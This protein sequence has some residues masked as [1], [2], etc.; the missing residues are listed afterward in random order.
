MK[1]LRPSLFFFEFGRFVLLDKE[2]NMIR[3]AVDVWSLSLGHLDGYD[4]GI[5][6]S[7]IE[8]YFEKVIARGVHCVWGVEC[9]SERPSARCCDDALACTGCGRHGQLRAGA[10]RIERGRRRA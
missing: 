6:V 4:A 1:V 8:R 10:E 5:A 3:R 9:E 7:R 2:L